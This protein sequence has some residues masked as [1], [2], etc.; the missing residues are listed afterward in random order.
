MGGIP[1]KI[2]ADAGLLDPGGSGADQADL[3]DHGIEGDIPRAGGQCRDHLEI[4][5]DAD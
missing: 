2:R 1:V 3:C 4:V 5:A